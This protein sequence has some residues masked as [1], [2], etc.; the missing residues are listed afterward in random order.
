[1]IKAYYSDSY[2]ADTETISM[3][4]LPLIAEG[5]KQEGLA[6]LVEPSGV[7]IVG[8]LRR[9]HRPSYVDSFLT[10]RGALA[11]SNGFEWSEGLRDG[12][13]ASNAGMLAGAR[14]ALVSGEVTANIGQ[15]YHHARWGS[16]NAYCT[17][18]G[19]ALVA[20]ENPAHTIFVL[21]CDEHQGEGTTEF[22]KSQRNLWNFSIF[23]TRMSEESLLAGRAEERLVSGW[24]EYESA[25]WDGLLNIEI[26]QPDLVIY[27]AGVDCYAFD[28]MG[29]AGLN[30]SELLERDRIVFE[31]LRD[32]GIPVLF[33]MAGGYGDK[34]VYHH[35]QTFRTAVAVCG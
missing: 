34:A 27:Q 18:N 1:M 24:G 12:V 9:L 17:F 14:S 29:F 22:V 28:G 32:M 23:G 5:V 25:L 4:K 30:S 8:A 3:S 35:L 16:G 2:G 13:I 20:Q 10:G 11:T 31:S 19:L 6:E 33:V 15:G 21:D 7:D 26:A